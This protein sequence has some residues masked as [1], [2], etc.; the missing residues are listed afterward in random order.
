MGEFLN[1]VGHSVAYTEDLCSFF[2]ASTDAARAQREQRAMLQTLTSAPGS[3]DQITQ[4]FYQKTRELMVSEAWTGVGISTKS[5]DVVR[6]VLKYV[7]IVWASEV[8]SLSV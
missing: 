3:A 8:V 1:F 6:D 7:P 4:F 2:I 5:V